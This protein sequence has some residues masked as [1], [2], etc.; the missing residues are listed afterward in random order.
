M[1]DRCPFCEPDSERIWME[2]AI[3]MVLWDAFPVDRGP[4]AGRPQEARRQHLRAC[5]PM[6]RPPCGR[7]LLKPGSDSKTSFTPMASTSA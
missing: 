5:R 6:S 1:P 4:H 7:W 2:N 3:G